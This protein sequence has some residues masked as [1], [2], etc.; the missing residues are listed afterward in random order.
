MNWSWITSNLK[1]D[2]HDILFVV[3]FMFLALIVFLIAAFLTQGLIA[4]FFV[5]LLIGLF[6]HPFILITLILLLVV[7]MQLHSWSR[8]KWFKESRK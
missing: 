3:G 2:L 4:Y 5:G 7:M 1:E 6:L 8:N